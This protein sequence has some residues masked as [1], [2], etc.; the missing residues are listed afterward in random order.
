MTAKIPAVLGT[1]AQAQDV[2]HPWPMN[3]VPLEYLQP[4]ETSD[5]NENTHFKS[6]ST[7]Q[8]CW[9]F[10]ENWLLEV[11][12]GHLQHLELMQKI[13]RRDCC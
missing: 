7:P 2:R 1:Q 5:G 6:Q 13:Y 11:H 3:M 8:G 9:G 12:T 4:R 10:Q